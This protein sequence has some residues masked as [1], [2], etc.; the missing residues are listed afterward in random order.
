MKK[1]TAV[2]A[3]V[4]L[5]GFTRTLQERIDR[6]T[7]EIDSTVGVAAVHVESGERIGVR[8][9]ERFPMG[10]VNKVPIAIAFMR[11]VDA[12]RF[13]LSDEVTID[14]ADF[15]PHHSPIRDAAKGRAV[16]LTMRRLVEAMLGESDNTAADVLLKLAGGAPAVSQIMRDLGASDIDVSRNKRQLAADLDLPG[17]ND[18]YVTDPR[19]TA[20]PAAMLGLLERFYSRQAGLSSKSHEF[21]MNIMAGSPTGERRIRAGAPA[22]AVVAHK[23][24]TMPGTV[25]D[26]GIITSP[27][28]KDHVLIVVFTKGGKTSTMTQ[29]ER[30]VASIT[31]TVYRDFV[32]WSPFRRARR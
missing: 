2:A 11:Q 25:N 24:G 9:N 6:I 21:L 13:S 7:S 8:E 4:L 1:L 28:G 22:D 32:G 20:T 16:K 26:V 14:A 18:A 17:G 5:T 19:D 3:L 10:S 15:A 30:A 29:R 23:T 12:G 31:R 27:N